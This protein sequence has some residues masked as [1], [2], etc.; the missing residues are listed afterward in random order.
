MQGL[1]IKSDSI[2]RILSG[3]KTWELR[4][5]ATRL[6]GRIALVKGGSK[7]IVATAQI[8]DCTGPL[9]L[10]QLHANLD[11]HQ[12]PLESLAQL[13]Y[14]KTYAVVLSD[15][16]AFAEP[17]AVINVRGGTWI[18][19]T[20]ENVPDRFAELDGVALPPEQP[21][22]EVTIPAPSPAT[23]IVATPALEPELVE[24]KA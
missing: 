24:A 2:E 18:N 20:P 7:K 5:V 1:F 4:G 17:I 9:S 14:P 19:L 23:E 16:K 22:I 12:V 6:R 13:P 10:E 11:K 8:A 21:K 15:V 3:Q